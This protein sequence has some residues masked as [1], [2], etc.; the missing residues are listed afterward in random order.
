MALD[1]G[2]IVGATGILVAAGVVVI[3]V[4]APSGSTAPH[5]TFQW[6][7][8]SISNTLDNT[9]SPATPAVTPSH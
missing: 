6:N 9:P 4:S 5:G 1:M 3:F 2:V 8:P 7:G